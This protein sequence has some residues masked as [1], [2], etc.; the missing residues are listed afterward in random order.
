MQSLT[1]NPLKTFPLHLRDIVDLIYFDGPL[2]T[3]FENQYGDY[4]LY[5]WCDVD[6]RCNR[7]LVFRVTQKFLRLYITQ[8]LSLRELILNP[9]D[10]FLYALD[11]DDDL[12]CQQVYLTS[13]NQLP[14]RYVPAVDSYYDFAKLDKTDTEAKLLVLQRIEE[15]WSELKQWWKQ[16]I[17]QAA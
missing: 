10:G 4:Y 9:V 7:W 5:H 15:D 12:I 13:P 8:K 14:D 11:L 2:L 1:G 6:Q 17:L 3:L 16:S